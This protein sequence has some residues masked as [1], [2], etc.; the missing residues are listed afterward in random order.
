M[1]NKIIRIIS[2]ILI[3]IILLPCLYA[4]GKDDNKIDANNNPGNNNT[5][6]EDISDSV[7]YASKEIADAIMAVFSSDEL[8][9]TGLVNFFSGADED[10][11][12]YIDPE[13]I[14]I[15]INKTPQ[16]IAEFEYLEDFAFY[17]PAG[18]SM[19]EVSVLKVKKEEESNIEKIKT[20]LEKRIT[21]VSRG[22]LMQY[23]PQEIPIL[24]N[25]KV[26]IVSNYVIL[27][28]TNDNGKAE[29][30]INTMLKAGNNTSLA[31][32]TTTFDNVKIEEAEQ[33]DITLKSEIE[34]ETVVETQK[35]TELPTPSPTPAPTSP[36]TQPPTPAPTSPPTQAPTPAPTQP[37]TSAAKPAATKEEVV[38]VAPEILFD[39]T[40]LE[41]LAQKQTEPPVTADTAQKKT[42]VPNVTVKSYS[43]NT[44]F[45]IGGKCETG[46]MIK[47]T[48]GTEEIYTGSD[49]GDYLVEVPFASSGSSTLK[50]TVISE[51]KLPSDEVSFIVKPQKNISYF[52]DYG[53]YGV[54]IGYNYMSYF[55]D[56]M[57]DFLGTNL[58]KD[59]EITQLR[60]R[61]EKRVKDLRDK[62]C[63]SEIV[64]LLVPNTSRIWK[65]DMPKRYTYYEG[66]TLLKQWKQALST[67][68]GMTVLDMTDLMYSY[69]NHEF[70]IWH[71][72]DSHWTEFGAFLGYEVLMKH[73]AQK[74]PDAAP[75]PITDFEFNN[76]EVNFGD[77]YATLGLSISDL[78]ETT[79]FVNF[80]FDP[81]HYNPD[82]N[83]GHV[84]IYDQNCALKMSA[85]PIHAR[86]QFGHTTQTNLS[87]LKLPTAYFFRDSFEG[88]LH[89]FYTDR[90]E[91]ATFRGMWD[92][93]FN[94]TQLA[95]MNPD[96]IIY[97]LSE[98]NIK[99]VLY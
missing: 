84:N 4:C 2:V 5:K 12:N 90:F 33:P 85:R 46:A 37:P 98:R 68:D 32:I 72:T 91:T 66:D 79:T 63:D 54:V 35:E 17:V 39:F 82:Y 88:P 56:C 81:P 75:R 21:R 78:R 31:N 42:P 43:H 20:I 86:V 48:G 83:T 3:C 50:L 14:G 34:T 93:G 44:S 67:V 7:N 49:H 41:T 97:I 29:K 24:E 60:T 16:P 95:N 8:P 58:L 52:E 87:G 26:I 76:I 28:A 15:M 22:E 25:A 1:K 47:V 64:Y 71:K 65:E 27:L 9:E 74:F 40:E 94:A 57:A 59:N 38:N 51:G 11:E 23:A 99:A 92:Y 62:G 96:Y 45:L 61:M 30:V 6:N 70:K 55:E 80:K 10:S 77:I 89:A 69:K 13:R 18:Q 73:I 36:P 53:A 19:F